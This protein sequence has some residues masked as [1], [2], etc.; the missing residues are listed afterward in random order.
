MTNEQLLI[1]ECSKFALYIANKDAKTWNDLCRDLT[2]IWKKNLNDEKIFDF[3][4]FDRC[5]RTVGGMSGKYLHSCCPA[6]LKNLFYR[7]NR[8]V[9]ALTSQEIMFRIKDELKI[10][11]YYE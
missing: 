3:L 8:A 6:E 4:A 10:G 2:I 7:N 9:I 1:E 5:H 11:N